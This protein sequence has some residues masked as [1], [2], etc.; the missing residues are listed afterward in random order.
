MLFR[1]ESA[2]TRTLYT[3]TALPDYVFD[4]GERQTPKPLKRSK[5]AIN[6]VQTVDLVKHAQLTPVFFVAKNEN[7]SPDMP[8]KKRRLACSHPTA[9]SLKTLICSH[10][11]PPILWSLLRVYPH[12]QSSLLTSL[13]SIRLSSLLHRRKASIH[14]LSQIP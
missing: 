8:N 14:Q 2:L 12:S 10:V 4:A 6:K 11:D 9:G 5:S 13:Q 7:P 1:V 3:S